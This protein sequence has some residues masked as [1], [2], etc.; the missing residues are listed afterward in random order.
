[1]T[2]ANVFL[3][4]FDTTIALSTYAVIGS[5]FNAVNQVSWISTAY[6]ITATAFQP[7]YGSF[8][9][10]LGRRDCFVAST[11]LF[12]FGTT[13]CGLA[14]S[15]W[16]LNIGRGMAG[17]GGGGLFTMA[18]VILSDMVPFHKRGLYQAA[19]N[20]V[21]GFGTACGASIGGLL[22]SKLNWRF[23]FLFQ[24]PICLFGI[25]IGY[26]LI[27]RTNNEPLL[28]E[29]GPERLDIRERLKQL[30]I[31]GA[32]NLI[33][34]LATLLA[35][36]NLGGNVVPWSS[37]WVIGFFIASSIFLCSFFLVETKMAQH[38]II[39][40]RMLR[41]RVAVVSIF[42]NVFAGMAVYSY[43]FLIPLFFQAVLLE[44]PAKVGVRLILPS[45]MFPIGGFVSG[46]IMS[47]WS[48][49]AHLVRTG[50]VIVAAG[51]ALAIIFN[52]KTSYWEYFACLLPVNFG[53]GLVYPSSLFLMLAGFTQKDQAIAT[54]TVYL[55]R[56]IGSVMGVA[57]GSVIVQNVLVKKLSASLADVPDTEKIIYAVRHSVEA[58]CDIPLEYR[59]VVTT[60]Y[61]DSLRYGFAACTVFAALAFLS[62][63]FGK[64][65]IQKR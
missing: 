56:N 61:L 47:R 7:L 41:G 65:S 25:V 60:C 43:M 31:L 50:T 33:I 3:S 55:F 38:P 42:L 5:E 48:L 22:A 45:T 28:E 6:L 62:S 24:I 19:N 16:M 23:G 51:C 17:M 37:I 40:I 27:P 34:G 49:L 46:W 13:L 18:T 2:W 14:S 44:S 39:P 29:A 57:I 59:S 30:D 54:S 21:Y 63:L 1:A 35:A 9:D 36:L 15:I 64:N 10:I 52:K 53:Q 12:L 26:V 8:S 20:T 32:V 11:S 58:I 4:G